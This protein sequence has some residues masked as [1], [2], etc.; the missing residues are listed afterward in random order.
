[1]FITQRG[2]RPLTRRW[3][4]AAADLLG[5]GLWACAGSGNNQGRH[6]SL[7]GTMAII[8][9]A[10][11]RMLMLIEEQNKK[12]GFRQEAR[13]VVVDP[14]SNWPLFAEK[15]RE[16]IWTRC[17]CVRLL[18]LGVSQ[19][20]AAGVQGAQ[21]HRSIRCNMR[22]GERRNVFYTGAAPTSR[23]SAVDYLMQGRRRVKRWVLAGTDYVYPA[24]PT[25]S[26]RPI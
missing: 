5:A 19:V 6:P 8:D 7:S 16:L 10:E 4:V 24:P 14:A 9:H 26:S 15:A 1:M 12:G 25:R 17:P 21:Q 23:R 13:A 11:G 22:R 20:G 2:P 3:P 18:D